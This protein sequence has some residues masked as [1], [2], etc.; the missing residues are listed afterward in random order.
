LIIGSC[1]E[2]PKYKVSI[3][4]GSVS[5]NSTTSICGTYV[6][7]DSNGKYEGTFTKGTNCN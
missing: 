6:T 5:A 7:L 3:D 1:S 2:I 4:A